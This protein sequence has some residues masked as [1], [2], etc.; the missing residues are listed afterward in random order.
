V[1]CQLPSVCST[2]EEVK[3]ETKQKRCR[4]DCPW[5]P[6]QSA[7]WRLLARL[8]WRSQGHR[9]DRDFYFDQ[10][11]GS[12]VRVVTTRGLMHR[13]LE[14]ATWFQIVCGGDRV[15]RGEAV[16]PPRICGA[17]LHFLDTCVAV[18]LV[19]HGHIFGFY[20]CTVWFRLSCP[21]R[22]CGMCGVIRHVRL[23]W[24]FFQNSG[25]FRSKSVVGPC[26]MQCHWIA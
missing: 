23:K 22:H 5:R 18:F 2:V 21:L 13:L 7:V 15:C 6:K 12:S 14:G 1:F 8:V 25:S 9:Y 16:H 24:Y 10:S 19:K 4:G 17:L 3:T 20:T 11:Q 26:H